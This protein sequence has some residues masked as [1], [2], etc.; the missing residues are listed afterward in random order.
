MRRFKFTLESVLTVRTKA[1]EDARIQLA[2]IT[3]VF[4]KQQEI[5]QEMIMAL[6]NIKKES[7][8]YLLSEPN[9]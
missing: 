8:Q 4:N 2:A 3:N 9:L 5:L 6:E 1:L 7:E